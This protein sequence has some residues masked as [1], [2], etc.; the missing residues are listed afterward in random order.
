MRVTTEE[1]SRELIQ[2]MVKATKSGLGV[3]LDEAA[4]RKVEWLVDSLSSE[5]AFWEKKAA[6]YR[7]ELNKVS[8]GAHSN[9]AVFLGSGNVIEVGNTE[10]DGM[11]FVN[12]SMDGEID[13]GEE[14]EPALT[15]RVVKYR[16]KQF[17]DNLYSSVD[18]YAQFP[19]D[20][21]E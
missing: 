16:V 18:L 4:V 7:D 13:T 3:T 8:R 1:N 9:G 14:E 10:D 19:E 12:I 5:R 21:E 15:F 17:A 20:G 6:A 11:G 2:N